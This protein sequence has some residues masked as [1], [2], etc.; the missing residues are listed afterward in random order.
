MT[1][2]PENPQPE[3]KVA[4]IEDLRDVREGLAMLI[5]GTSG[6]RCVGRFRSVEEASANIPK[7]LP[8]VVMTDIGL[9]AWTASKESNT[10]GS[11]TPLCPSSR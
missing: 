11:A 7:E 10:F 8:D 4:I 3:I 1:N 2:A 9:P 6:F 5:N